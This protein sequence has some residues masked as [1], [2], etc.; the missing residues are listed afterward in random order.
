MMMIWVSM[1]VKLRDR[2]EAGMRAGEI[3]GLMGLICT[4]CVSPSRGWALRSRVGA[5]SD[6]ACGLV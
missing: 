3:R 4:S 1:R 6:G 5:V 2:T